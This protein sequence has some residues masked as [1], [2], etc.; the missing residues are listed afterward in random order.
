V[1]CD[2][3]EGRV[4]TVKAAPI[5]DALTA[6]HMVV[7]AGKTT[8]SAISSS[9]WSKAMQAEVGLRWALK[10]AGLEVPIEDA[11]TPA[12]IGQRGES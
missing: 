11:R 5:F 10:E 9:L 8:P 3:Q 6:L 2:L 7:E 4:L 12:L 1:G